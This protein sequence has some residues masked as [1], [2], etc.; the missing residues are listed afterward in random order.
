LLTTIALA[1]A[2]LYS[3][4]PVIQASKEEE[5]SGTKDLVTET[6]DVP[7]ADVKTDAPADVPAE[8]EVIDVT[9]TETPA[10]TKDADIVD[11]PDLCDQCDVAGELDSAVDTEASEVDVVQIDTT[12]VDVQQIDYEIGKE[13]ELDSD[14]PG[15][16]CL[17]DPEGGLCSGPCTA[18]CPKL[19]SC[20]TEVF[21]S[22]EEPVCVPISW[23]ECQPCEGETVCPAVDFECVTFEEGA[24]CL[25]VCG[26]GLVCSTGYYCLELAQAN[27]PVCLPS[28]SSCACDAGTVGETFSCT[29]SNQHGACQ[30]TKTC[31]GATGFSACSAAVPAAETCDGV[32]NDCNGSVDEFWPE[33]GTP[34]D[35]PDEDSCESGVVSCDPEG[36]GTH[37]E[38]DV[39]SAETCDGADNDCDG[40]VDEEWTELGLPCDSNDPDSCLYGIFACAPDGLGLACEG[41]TPSPEAC[42]GL[43]NDCDGLV[44]D[45]WP[46]LGFA[47]DGPDDDDCE[48]GLWE[49][50]ADGASVGCVG[51]VVKA[52]VCDSA[53]N[54]CDGKVDED[55]ADLGEPCDSI[56]ADLCPSG[57]T[58]C[59]PDGVST[60]CEGDEPIVESCDG[61]DNDCD[62]Q[63]DEDWPHLYQPCDGSDIDLCKNGQFTCTAG[64]CADD[65]GWGDGCYKKFADCQTWPDAQDE[66]QAWGG[67]L[68]IPADEEEETFVLGFGGE[69]WVGV[70][71]FAPEGEWMSVTGEPFNQAQW[72]DGHPLDDALYILLT[73]GHQWGAPAEDCSPFVCRKSMSVTCSEPLNLV[74]ECNGQDDDC[75]GFVDETWPELGTACDGPDADDCPNGAYEC[76]PQGNGTV[77]VD[78]VVD[79]ELCDGLDNDCDGSVDE[80]WDE[81]GT[82][83]DGADS[84][85]CTNGVLVCNAEGDGTEC[86]VEDPAGLPEICNNLADDDCDGEVDEDT[87]ADPCEPYRPPM[88][89]ALLRFN[90]SIGQSLGTSEVGEG[91]YHGALWDITR[92]S[93][94]AAVSAQCHDTVSAD[95]NVPITAGQVGSV[96]LWADKK[97]AYADSPVLQLLTFVTDAEGRPVEGLG[98][99]QASLTAFWGNDQISLAQAGLGVYAGEYTLPP[100]AFESGGTLKIT[101][102]AGGVSSPVFS[103]T[104]VKLPTPAKL[105]LGQG[106]VGLAMPLGPVMQGHT[107]ETT[108]WANTGSMTVASLQLEIDYATNIVEFV[109]FEDTNT[110]LNPASV[111]D[112]A[113]AG[114]IALATTRN[115]GSDTALVTGEIILGKLLFKVKEQATPGSGGQFLGSVQELLDTS[116]NNILADG[117]MQMH[118][119]FGQSNTGLL[120]VLGV[121]TLGMLA[122]LED[123]H[124]VD[125]TA[126]G[127]AKESSAVLVATFSNE[128]M[129][130]APKDQFNCSPGNP[131]IASCSNG[132]LFPQAPGTTSVSVSAETFTR[133]FPVQ[134][135]AL[136]EIQLNL[137][138]SQL[139]Q[140]SGWEGHYQG[141][142]YSVT[143]NLNGPGGPVE[144]DL[145]AFAQLK[146]N[147][148]SVAWWNSDLAQMQ[149]A[150]PG[151]VLITAST[152]AGLPVATAELAVVE[153]AVEPLSLDVLVPALIEIV[154]CAPNPVPAPLGEAQATALVSGLFQ[155][156]GATANYAVFLVCADGNRFE[157]TGDPDVEVNAGS[158]E[159]TVLVE[160]DSVTATGTGSDGLNAELV[161]GGATI[162]AGLGMVEVVLPD[163]VGADFSPST[164]QLAVTQ[165]DPAAILKGLPVAT[166][167]AVVIQFDDGSAMDM[168]IDM[169]TQYDIISGESLITICQTDEAPGCLPGSVQSTGEGTGTALVKASWPGTYLDTVEAIAEVEVVGHQELVLEVLEDFDPPVFEEHALSHIEGTGAYQTARAELVEWFTDGS[170]EIVTTSEDAVLLVTDE[171]GI[172]DESVISIEVDKLAAAAPG[173][174]NVQGFYLDFSSNTVEMIVEGPGVTDADNKYYADITELMLEQMPDQHGLIGET[175][176]SPRVV[177]TFNDSTRRVIVEAGEVTVSQLVVFHH[178]NAKFTDPSD[179]NYALIHP[180]TGTVTLLNSGLVRTWVELEQGVDMPP[181][182]APG[183]YPL[184]SQ[185]APLVPPTH[186]PS[187]WVKCNLDPAVGDVDLGNASGLAVPLLVEPGETVD[188]PVRINSGDDPLGAFSIEIDFDSTLFEVKQP[189]S[190]NLKVLIPADAAAINDPAPGKIKITVVPTNNSEL[191]GTNTVATFTLAARN[192]KLVQGTYAHI[193]GTILEM[194]VNCPGASCPALEGAGGASPRQFVAGA[195][196]IDP[197]GNLAG[198]GDFNNDGKFSAADLQAIVNYV[199]D[200]GNPEFAGYNLTAANI[201]PDF[202]VGGQPKIQAFDAYSGALVNVGLSHFVNV[203]YETL[204][205]TSMLLEVEVRDGSEQ[206]QAMTDML[207]VRFE[208]GLVSG[209]DLGEYLPCDAG[210]TYSEKADGTQVP[211]RFLYAAEHTGSGFYEAIVPGVTNLPPDQSIGVAVILQNYQQGGWPKGSPTVYMKSPLE[212]ENSPFEPLVVPQLTPC[213]PIAEECDG[214]D[215]DCDGLVDEQIPITQCGV[216]ACEHPVAGCVDGQVPECDPFLGAGLE[217]CDGIDNDCNGQVDEGYPAEECGVGACHHVVA[218]PCKNGVY[219]PC[220]PLAPALEEE[221]WDAVDDDCDGELDNGCIAPCDPENP[222]QEICDDYDNDCNGTVD[223]LLG[224]GIICPEGCSPG[225]DI[226]AGCPNGYIDFGEDCDDGN[227]I[228]TDD[229]KSDCTLA[230]CGDGVLHEGVEECDDGNINW[231]D[232]CLGNCKLPGCGDLIVQPGEECDDGNDFQGDGCL[233]DCKEATCG[234]GILYEGI[235]ECDEGPN[236]GETCEP[237]C[238]FKFICQL[239]CLEPYVVDEDLC[240]CVCDPNLDCGANYILDPITCTCLCDL[241]CGMINGIQAVMEPESCTCQCLGD[242]PCFEPQ[243][244]WNADLCECEYKPQGSQDCGDEICDE[245]AGENCF[246]CFTDCGS[247]CKIDGNNDG[248]MCDTEYGETCANCHWDCGTCCGIDK[249]GDG[250]NC[251]SDEEFGEDCLNCEEDCGSC[252]GQDGD[253]DGEACDF[254]F[255]EDCTSCPDDC[256]ACP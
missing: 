84:D 55:W 142:L 20:S 34:C 164:T 256:G 60:V 36:D 242:Y 199:V 69:T 93:D 3:C 176:G 136:D 76:N 23:H 65:T 190:D 101:A 82:P 236:G 207:Q 43:D 151:D 120:S 49:C 145:T 53:D 138:D 119:G 153:E 150:A 14:C 99:V 163:P 217:T 162:A 47:C 139:Q 62:G 94:A 100:A 229:C 202:E 102:F 92:A 240:L 248:D 210:C 2:V 171:F 116:G 80:T 1:V 191:Y 75:D 90:S 208:L 44:D 134:T 183:P 64:E 97:A 79:L 250:D 37:C 105:T 81:L 228:D 70:H 204:P 189:S 195:V 31:E 128:D 42:D 146:S 133:D 216:G 255:G 232:E 131:A 16:I 221:C 170:N 18:G 115:V 7:A 197:P 33:I 234:D 74:E 230:K 246:T 179:S 51:D 186:P 38:G 127:G 132:Q 87:M 237:D 224:P 254:N 161:S 212:N 56:D 21:N 193:G 88:A 149:G 61:Q 241:Q 35:G 196:S 68:V 118:S 125:M 159:A 135:Y 17:D 253:G 30:G 181:A 185:P 235:E 147:D 205:P 180:A 126:I 123:L 89:G 222:E 107:V 243:H 169:R 227:L 72:S 129:T 200:P 209:D 233:N 111:V 96:E 22:D 25:P 178:A 32:D 40:M 160:G 167:L 173:E 10:E 231:F 218:Q 225:L 182:F 103:A 12:E 41:D 11:V 66:C 177:A 57:E 104:A 6:K 114:V 251:D 198:N 46:Q 124:L 155:N 86:G 5:D 85:L 77:C 166:E 239:E 244:V 148:D 211:E 245:E 188:I 9:T 8:V 13:C 27:G 58:V 108:V 144:T 154:D 45:E 201:Y 194:S 143:A 192:S 106:E 157:I 252:C 15:T 158:G 48:G 247:C 59:A 140:I 112:N 26:S 113:G 67:A 223:D 71:R 214:K 98:A 238:M 152:A 206:P 220:E 91:L 249:D 73:E 29:K 121:K 213:V 4:S 156:E 24:F 122:W 172:P 130:P 83:C 95:E 52:E 28:S 54:D 168:T 187:K 175:V 63:N 39:Q 165:A 219:S 137:N 226:C 19:W 141:T 174:V 109:G 184:L 215:N 110:G 203:T 50:T 78:L 117:A